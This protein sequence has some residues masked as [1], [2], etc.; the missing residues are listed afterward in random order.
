[1]YIPRLVPHRD[2]EIPVGPAEGE[3][4]G[5][6]D[7]AGGVLGEGAGDGDDGG[8]LAEGLPGKRKV[9]TRWDMPETQRQR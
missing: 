6:V 3:G 2:P 9:M 4:E 1:M 7:E 8:Q 5:I